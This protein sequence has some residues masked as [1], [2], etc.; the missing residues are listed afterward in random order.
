[1]LTSITAGVVGLDPDGRVD[2]MNPAAIS[3]LNLEETA[4]DHH[5]A[6]AQAVPEFAGLLARLRSDDRGVTQD[7]IRITR[8][9]KVED[10]LVRLAE[11][12]SVDGTLEGYVVAFDDVTEIL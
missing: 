4:G 10:L 5:D 9:G 6:L 2:F 8:H 7:E 11:R 3:L 1:M 12:R